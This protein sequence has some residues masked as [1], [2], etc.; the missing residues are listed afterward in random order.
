[1]FYLYLKKLFNQ[2]GS[3][4]LVII[5]NSISNMAEYMFNPYSNINEFCQL[6]DDDEDVCKHL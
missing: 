6:L 3:I 4:Y 5:H 1:M 2:C